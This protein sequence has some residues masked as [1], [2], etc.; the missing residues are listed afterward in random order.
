VPK[1]AAKGL[2]CTQADFSR[3]GEIVAK[4]I[5]LHGKQRAFELF[6]VLQ[7]AVPGT[8]E[9][10]ALGIAIEQLG[11]HIAL[12]AVQPPGDGGL[13]HAQGMRSLQG[14]TRARHAQKNAQIVPIKVVHSRLFIYCKFAY[15]QRQFYKTQ[16][17]KV[18]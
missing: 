2:G 3:E 12:Q 14:R 11:A 6:H 10:V 15:L 1:I 17:I 4:H 13:V 8:G 5:G 7:Q 18:V 16:C 9:A